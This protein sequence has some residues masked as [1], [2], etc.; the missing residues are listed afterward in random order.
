MRF[1]EPLRTRLASVM[2]YYNI[3]FTSIFGLVEMPRGRHAHGFADQPLRK[4]LVMG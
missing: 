3:T 1:N 2:L 4:A